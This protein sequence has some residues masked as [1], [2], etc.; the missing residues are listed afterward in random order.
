MTIG[1]GADS[2]AHIQSLLTGVTYPTDKK[3][4]VETA[5]R[6]MAS[7]EI[8]TLLEEFPEQ[9]Y[10]SS[11]DVMRVYGEVHGSLDDN[12]VEYFPV[13]GKQSGGESNPQ[14]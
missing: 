5:K 9:V 13:E 11:V 10:E 14:V 7:E 12:E 4:L 8:M 6:N 2:P 1:L 3:T